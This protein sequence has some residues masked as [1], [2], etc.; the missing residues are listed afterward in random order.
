MTQR[1]IAEH[2]GVTQGAISQVLRDT[3]GR[4]GFKYEPGQKLVE[5]HVQRCQ[6]GKPPCSGD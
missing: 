5:L 2:I 4:R 3:T 1:E 6:G